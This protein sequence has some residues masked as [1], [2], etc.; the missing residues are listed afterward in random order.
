M[1]RP[2]SAAHVLR[3]AR[4]KLNLS[5]EKLAAAVGTSTMTIKKV[6][7]CKSAL[8]P[9][10]AQRISIITRL[11]TEQLLNNSDPATPK[12]YPELASISQQTFD[13]EA[14]RLATGIRK[15]LKD[16]KTP[17][18]F[19]VLRWAIYEKL[20]ELGKDFGVQAPRPVMRELHK[21]RAARKREPAQV[22]PDSGNA[23]EKSASR[24]HVPSPPHSVQRS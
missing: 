10:L 16:C 20:A 24:R 12:F 5:Q 6:E 19:F 1:P 7:A 17:A 2:P 21:A 18:R 13:I 11:D 9:K 8:N 15:M 14:G 3:T 22:E 23:S 4:Q